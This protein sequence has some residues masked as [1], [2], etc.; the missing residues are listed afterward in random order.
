M[1]VITSVH[2]RPITATGVVGASAGGMTAQTIAIGHP[3]GAGR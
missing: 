3:G 1:A 2:S